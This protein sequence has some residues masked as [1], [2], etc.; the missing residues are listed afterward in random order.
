MAPEVQC[1]A[2][3]LLFCARVHTGIMIFYPTTAG[4]WL[5]GAGYVECNSLLPKVTTLLPLFKLAVNIINDR[6]CSIRGYNATIW[7]ITV[8]ELG[9]GGF[10]SNLPPPDCICHYH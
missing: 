1:L 4:Y 9:G 5:S 6:C 10:R 2:A 7:W 8:A 3:F